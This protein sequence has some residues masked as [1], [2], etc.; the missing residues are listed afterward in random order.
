MGKISLPRY[1]AHSPKS[2]ILLSLNDVFQTIRPDVDTAS[3][4][5]RA[6]Y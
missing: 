3:L 1:L 5:L 6:P 2:D 4:P